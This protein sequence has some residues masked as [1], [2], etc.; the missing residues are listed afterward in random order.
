MATILHQKPNNVSAENRNATA[1]MAFKSIV[2]GEKQKFT[3]IQG[4]ENNI[5]V[6][7]NRVATLQNKLGNVI[8]NLQKA[9]NMLQEIEVAVFMKAQRNTA[10]LNVI[11]NTKAEYVQNNPYDEQGGTYNAL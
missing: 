11:N 5:A 10:A 3:E 1:S 9:A 8:N 2:G 6:Q 4:L 7:Q